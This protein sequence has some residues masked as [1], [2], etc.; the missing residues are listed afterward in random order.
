MHPGLRSY[1]SLADRFHG[2]PRSASGLASASDTYGTVAE[3]APGVELVRRA[4]RRPATGLPSGSIGEEAFADAGAWVG[5]LS[6]APGAASGWHHHGEWDS[7]A[8]VLRGVL[9]WEFG[10]RGRDAIEVGSG[11]TGRMPGGLVHRDV[12]AGDEPLSMVLFR[13][14]GGPLTIDVDGPDAGEKR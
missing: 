9:R 3:R 14:G 6:L 11:D 2:L 1:L 10:S 8:C 7:Y 4:E 13:A 5:F 12:S